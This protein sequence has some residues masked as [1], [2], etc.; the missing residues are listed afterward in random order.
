MY[1][2]SLLHSTCRSRSPAH[3]GKV[4]AVGVREEK[5]R[6]CV[7]HN[8]ARW[9]SDGPADKKK[10]FLASVPPRERT[11]LQQPGV[12]P[13]HAHKDMLQQRR[14]FRSSIS[15][16]RGRPRT[17]LWEALFLGVLFIVTC[18]NLYTYSDRRE[19]VRGSTRPTCRS[20][21][22]PLPPPCRF[23]VGAPAAFSLRSCERSRFSDPFCPCSLDIFTVIQKSTRL[24]QMHLPSAAFV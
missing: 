16:R 1:V 12:L 2:S 4:A 15:D 5:R 11:V 3:R 23:S 17:S 13:T 9:L 8:D 20:T 14:S 22:V 6:L 10:C 24:G 18:I 21:Y 7:G 19:R